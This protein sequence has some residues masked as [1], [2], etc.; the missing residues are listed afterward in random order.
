MAAD[1]PFDSE[2]TVVRPTPGG[3]RAGAPRRL[4]D[5][6]DR[7]PP[8]EVDVRGEIERVGVNPIVAAASPLLALCSQLRYSASQGDIESLRQR[9]VQEIRTFENKALAA[10]AAPETVRIAR[11]CLCA[12]VD[13][14][15]LNTPWGQNSSW[16]TTTIV[17]TFF[18]ETYGGR[19]FFEIL[20]RLERD[21][22]HNIDVLE[23][24]YLCLSLGF[25]GELR[26]DPRGAQEHARIRDSL[27]R[28]IRVHRGE[29]ERDLAVHWRGVDAAHRPLSSYIPIWVIAT[30]AVALCMGAY[31]GLAL[32]LGGASDA[33]FERL[34]Q[35]PP[36]GEVKMAREAPP[37]A[38]APVEKRSGIRQFLADEIARNLV[39]VSE[40]NRAVNVRIK[41][42]GLFASGSDAIDS[43][44]APLLKRI[45]EALQAEPGKVIIEG[46]TDN[47]PIKNARFPSNWELSMA[48]AK[49]VLNALSR[50]VS[51][52]SRL[53]ADGR[54]DA[55]PVAPN[56]TPEGRD[57]NRRIEVVLVKQG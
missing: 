14:V 17:L 32:A 34:A 21:P 23:L 33:T 25:E 41:G 53:S 48:R 26:I 16:A 49:A 24:M 55:E 30:V 7:P 27:F 31:V 44:Y 28:T 11:Y 22:A 45:G 5:A 36:T 10:G 15:V 1:D 52:D 57:Q 56:D 18:N 12:L 46:H 50:Y 51:D 19:R 37:P 2:R 4:A 35:L 40:D 3:R 29:F 38:P 6:V 9:V 47:V 39:T 20:T 43:R 13:D 54:G 42:S 8:A